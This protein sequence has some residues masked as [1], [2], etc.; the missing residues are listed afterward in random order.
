[1]DLVRGFVLRA[2]LRAN[3]GTRTLNAEGRLTHVVLPLD[4]G[5]SGAKVRPLEVRDVKGRLRMFEAPSSLEK[6]FKIDFKRSGERTLIDT[7]IFVDSGLALMEANDG[8]PADVQR[9]ITVD[10]FGAGGL[11]LNR[12]G[13]IHAPFYMYTDRQSA[14]GIEDA[15]QTLGIWANEDL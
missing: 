4:V 10:T 9:I 15:K 12:D 1:M 8:Y 5:A 13:D 7:S 6:G 3:V 14:A 11:I 2:P